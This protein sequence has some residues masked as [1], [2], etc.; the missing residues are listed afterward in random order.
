MTS[1]IEGDDVALQFFELTFGT[2]AH[3][4]N[5]TGPRILAAFMAISSLGESQ[6]SG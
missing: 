5:T 6:A 3:G 2:L 1:Q 4:G